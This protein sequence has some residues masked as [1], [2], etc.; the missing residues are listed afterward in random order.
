MTFTK[1]PQGLKRKLD[2]EEEQNTG[3]EEHQEQDQQPM[4]ISQYWFHWAL[5]IITQTVWS[6]ELM[7]EWQ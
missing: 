7:S 4:E 3:D 1:K 6:D 5:R 2:Y